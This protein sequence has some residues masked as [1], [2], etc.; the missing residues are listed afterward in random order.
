M[1]R[2]R[3]DDDDDDD[4]DYRPKKKGRSRRDEHEDEDEDEDDRPLRKK[5]R[6]R[7]DDDEDEDED[8]DDDRP[9]PK[10]KR[11]GVKKSRKKAGSSG[12]LLLILGL[13]GGFVLLVGGGLAVFFLFIYDTP[14]SAFED[15]QNKF[16]AKDY[17]GVYDRFD[18]DAR[19]MFDGVAEL[20]KLDPSMAAH[21]N[22]KGKELFVA[23]C[24]ESDKKN[25]ASGKKDDMFDRWKR[26]ST[27]DSVKE[28]GD[29]ATL[30]VKDPDGK[31]STMYMKKEDG[32]WKLSP[33]PGVGK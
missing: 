18:S 31:T 11:K 16:V 10:K 4:D 7:D 21:T 20:A 19:K 23:L 30:T 14:K 28:D 32:R 25:A 6:A 5:A 33:G 27:V 22:K 12:P 3:R 26:K 9:V 24:E 29:K 1:P 13:V 2:S 15:I 8:E 17:G